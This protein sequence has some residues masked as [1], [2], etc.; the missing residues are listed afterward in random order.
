MTI[1]T[2]SIQFIEG[3]Q[4]AERNG[5]RIL[6]QKVSFVDLASVSNDGGCAGAIITNIDNGKWEDVPMEF[7]GEMKW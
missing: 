2:L 3:L 7:E 4:F 5:K 6:Q 1:E